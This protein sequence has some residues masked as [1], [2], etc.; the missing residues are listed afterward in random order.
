MESDM[1]SD[2]EPDMESDME[3][4][5]QHNTCTDSAG[6]EGTQA[7]VSQLKVLR[8]DSGEPYDIIPALDL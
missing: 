7:I 6:K 5:R 8:D 3:P 2:M 1:E 4:D